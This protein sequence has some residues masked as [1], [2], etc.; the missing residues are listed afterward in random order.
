MGQDKK[1]L[2]QLLTFIKDLYDNPDN[3]EFAAGI[4]AIVLSDIKTGQP[5]EEWT[6]QINEIYELCLRKN[7]RE[8]AE[9]LYKDFPITSVA[10]DLVDLFVKMEDARRA[11]DFDAF[12]RFLFL[13]I[14]LIV[15]AILSDKDFIAAY[16]G[17]RGLKPITKFNYEK[18]EYYRTDFIQ[19]VKGGD[20]Q[21]SKVAKAALPPSRNL[22]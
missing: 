1:Q 9:D 2:S 22:P 14:E 3:K 21:T 20:G 5:K 11:N 19:Y 8:Q 6:A 15:G 10:G 4:Q 18:K 7:L 16:E 13:Q 17:I 12:G